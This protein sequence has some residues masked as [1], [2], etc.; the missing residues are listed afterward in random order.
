VATKQRT[1][2]TAASLVARGRKDAEGATHTERTK[3]EQV[4]CVPRLMCVP[5]RLPK[6]FAH[7]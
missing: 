5:A 4:N 1:C 2:V 3:K 6:P 7:K